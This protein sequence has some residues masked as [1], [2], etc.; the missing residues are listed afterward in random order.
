MK[1]NDDNDDIFENVKLEQS[2]SESYYSLFNDCVKYI[3]SI[4]NYNKNISNETMKEKIT[5]KLKEISG[6][7]IDIILIKD[8]LK[9]TLIQYYLN[10]ENDNK[11]IILAIVNYYSKMFYNNT[12]DKFNKWLT[13]DNSE[14]MNIFEMLIEKQISLDKQIEY[15]NDLFSFISTRDNSIFFQILKN[16]K[17]NIFHLCVKQNNLYLL[18][19]LYEKIKNYFPLLNILDIKN[20]EGLTPLH[21]SC[22]YSFKII[23]DNL[24]LLN[25]DINIKDSKDNTPLHYAVQSGNV[26]LTKKLILFGANKSCRNSNNIKPKDIAI[27]NGNFS[28]KKLFNKSPF[29][30]ISSIKNKKRENLLISLAIICIIIKLYY[31]RKKE[32]GDSTFMTLLYYLS[33]IFDIFICGFILYPK[34]CNKTIYRNNSLTKNKFISFHVKTKYENIYKS[35]N[36]NLDKLEQLCPVCK[37]IRPPKTKHCFICNKCINNWDHHCYWLNICI[38]KET[39]NLFI[40]FLVIL[41]ITIVLNVIIF[42]DIFMSIKIFNPSLNYLNMLIYLFII[43][44]MTIFCWGLYSLIKQFNQI[45]K[46]K[47]IDKQRIVSLEDILS[48][49]SSSSLNESLNQS[50]KVSKYKDINNS[51]G[52]GESIEFQE[53]IN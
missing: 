28:M 39:Y 14:N 42:G 33:F 50:V 4:A 6:R 5:N 9:N 3:D 22:Y 1:E 30:N 41:F 35:N 47:K 45:K 37:I 11:D 44:I 31:F 17:N 48:E 49:S 27:K 40:F 2:G 51:K 10:M 23:A 20:I 18:L 15:F 7:G 25:C 26:P 34:I 32:K 36:Y 46:N 43:C 38:N 52:E 53:F 8:N 19:F 29:N 16:R 24:L 21:L 13:N 12:R